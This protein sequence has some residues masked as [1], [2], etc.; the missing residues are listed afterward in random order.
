GS[1]PVPLVLD[2]VVPY[3]MTKTLDYNNM[4]LRTEVGNLTINQTENFY[5][6][7]INFSLQ[8]RGNRSLTLPNLNYYLLTSEGLIYSLH[9]SANGNQNIAPRVKRDITLNTSI[10]VDV[11]ITD[12]Q[13]LVTANE[14]EIELPL[15]YYELPEVDLDDYT[16][17]DGD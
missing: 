15:S 2:N 1:V 6:T 16:S 7:S 3:G 5:L 11:D 9:S 13:L 14:D 4:G 8:N 10:P 12:L 17:P